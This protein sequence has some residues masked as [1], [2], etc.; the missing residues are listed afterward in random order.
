MPQRRV[1]GGS[2]KRSLAMVCFV[3]VRAI[4]KP[5]GLDNA[6]RRRR[7]FSHILSER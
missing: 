2:V 4:A 6:T 7:G 1:G 3:Y 5:F